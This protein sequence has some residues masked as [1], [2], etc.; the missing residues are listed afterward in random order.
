MK[1]TIL[2]AAMA[3]MLFAVS[4]QKDNSQE[5]NSAISKAQKQD[6]LTADLN[7]EFA[8][9]QKKV[10]AYLLPVEDVAKLINTPDVLNV[11]FVLGYEN[12][13]IQIDVVGVD[14]EGN[15]LGTVKSKILK[16]ADYGT[17]LAKLNQLSVSKTKKRTALQNEHL[18]SPQAAFAGIEAW[19]QKL[20][21]VSDLNEITSYNG[22]R[23]VHFTLEAEVLQ[24]MINKSSANIGVFLGLNP[25]G[26]VTTILVGLDKNNAVKK[27]SLT[28]KEE[29]GDDDDVYDGV[30]PS[31]PY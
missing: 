24:A 23:F 30:R 1:N 19:Q 6:W 25:K 13:T 7:S 20:N 18:L 16:E 5:D 3:A 12:N 14:K 9:S 10:T 27:A 15:E 22:D 8:D 26:K 11:R 21:T 29:L 17:E 31:P 4:C 2:C 28:S